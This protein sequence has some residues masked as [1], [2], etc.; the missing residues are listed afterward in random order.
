MLRHNTSITSISLSSN[1]IN[2]KGCLAISYALLKNTSLTSIDLF[3]NKIGAEG[4]DGA[5]SIANSLLKNTSITSLNLA[6]N[7]IG[8]AGDRALVIMLL[9]NTSITSLNFYNQYIGSTFIQ[10]IIMGNV[11]Y[12]KCRIN[13]VMYY[14]IY[15]NV[16]KL[17]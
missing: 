9:H 6:Y 17:S 12:K 15:I 10:N 1:N 4:A 2:Y 11:N 5:I 13:I 14:N 16:L 3:N 7:N 8:E